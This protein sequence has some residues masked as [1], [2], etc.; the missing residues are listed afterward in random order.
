[1]APLGTWVTG[2]AM[3]KKF[4]LQRNKVLIYISEKRCDRSCSY[5]SL[6]LN[7]NYTPVKFPDRE[8]CFKLEWNETLETRFY[9][10]A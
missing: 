2:S 1:M 3:L 8:R 4:T 5:I 10:T 9:G 7:L 6:H